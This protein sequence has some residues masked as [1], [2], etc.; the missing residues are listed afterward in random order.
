VTGGPAPARSSLGALALFDPSGTSHSGNA[1]RGLAAAAQ[2]AGY[3]TT[4]YGHERV[5]PDPVPTGVA[6]FDRQGPGELWTTAGRRDHR[7]VVR[8]A[9]HDYG[10][11]PGRIFCDL[12]LDRTA[13]SR[14]AAIDASPSTVF[15]LHRVGAFD[16]IPRRWS[17]RIRGRRFG[18]RAVLRRLGRAGAR[19]VTHTDVV[20]SR[21]ADFVPEDQISLLGWP[22]MS[23]AAPS[24]APDW[25]PSVDERLV[26]LAGSIR[27]EKGFESFIRGVVAGGAPFDRLV[28]PGR[29]PPAFRSL[30]TI[31]D[32]RVELW[33][34]WLDE[35][36]YF[37]LFSRAALVVLPY[38]AR[39][40]D[41]GTMSS[42]LLEAMA[43]GRPLLVSPAIAHLL[44]DAY[45]GAHVADLSDDGVSAA[46]ERA[47]GA[48]DVL[49]RSAMSVGRSHIASHHTYEQYAAGLAHAGGLPAAPPSLTPER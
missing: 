4:V 28:V 24:L 8:E 16:H 41:R 19:F 7:R 18:N 26:L 5:R 15:T 6:W 45:E 22:V 42:V 23:A 43:F 29:L 12:G 21:I 36:E 32:P 39:Y 33:D 44:P 13:A 25:R 40:T 47:F 34:R 27:S 3:D 48:L 17:R 10:P 31:T 2:E 11:A 49:E 9:V 37:D 30:T 35:S 46:L 14:G 1:L 20:A 38:D